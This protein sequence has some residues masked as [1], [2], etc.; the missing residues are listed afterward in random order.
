MICQ[1]NDPPA[2]QIHLDLVTDAA[3]PIPGYYFRPDPDYE[4]SALVN[5]NGDMDFSQY[6][7]AIEIV[8]NLV[9]GSTLHRKFWSGDGD[10]GVK[11]R[12]FAYN[13]ESNGGSPLAPIGSN[14]HQFRQ[15]TVSNQGLTVSFCYH[16]DDRGAKIETPGSHTQ[17]WYGIYLGDDNHVRA[18]FL[19]HPVISNGGN[20][21]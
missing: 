11:Y 1:A 21:T 15:I 19:I 5:K 13:D 12:V 8:I 20:H 3:T 2:I 9:D 17:S 10:D 6:N 16:N 7:Q 18:P 14:H 4:P